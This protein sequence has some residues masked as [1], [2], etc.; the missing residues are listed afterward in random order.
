M[1]KKEENNPSARKSFASYAYSHEQTRDRMNEWYKAHI[2][3]LSLSTAIGTKTVIKSLAEPESISG[4]FRKL[5]EADTR[6][7]IENGQLPKDCAKN[8]ID[9]YKRELQKKGIEEDLEIPSIIRILSDYTEGV[10][11]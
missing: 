2:D 6:K 8:L 9:R 1:R 4:Y 11:T 10:G 7:K 3:H 5:L